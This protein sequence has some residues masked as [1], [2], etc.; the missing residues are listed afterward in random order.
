MGLG[1]GIRDAGPPGMRDPGPGKKPF[2]IPDPGIKK[3]PD[4][5]PATLGKSPGFVACRIGTFRRSCGGSAMNW[6]LRSPVRTLG[7][8]VPH[9]WPLSWFRILG[10]VHWMTDPDP[11]LSVSGFQET[12]KKPVLWI[13]IRIHFGQLD[14]D[15]NPEG[16]EWTTKVKKFQVLKCLLF[17]FEGWKTL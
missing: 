4:P 14:R 12:N 10:S 7:A 8:S 17:S 5:G 16:Q 2:R 9:P 3:A 1:S 15:P 11:A 6:L 13:R